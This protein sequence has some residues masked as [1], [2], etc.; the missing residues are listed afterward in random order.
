MRTFV[1][2]LATWGMAVGVAA[3][4]GFLLGGCGRPE[5]K[6]TAPAVAPTPVT[7]PAVV[8]AEPV[9]DPEWTKERVEL[10]VG[11]CRVEVDTQTNFWMERPKADFSLRY[12]KCLFSALTTM[13]TLAGY[14]EAPLTWHGELAEKGFQVSCRDS[15]MGG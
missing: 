8:A 9:N 11:A 1:A 13:T 7:A 15:A 4:S 2:F 5:D 10:F 6:E 14:L 3:A 12:C